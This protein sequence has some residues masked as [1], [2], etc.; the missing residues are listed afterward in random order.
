[1]KIFSEGNTSTPILQKVK[2][3]ENNSEWLWKGNLNNTIYN[4]FEN[5]VAFG[6]LKYLALSDYP[7]LKDVWYG[8]LH[9]NVFCSLKHLVVERHWKN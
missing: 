6:K 3:A 7:E 2:I 1:M 4:M 5:K 8:Q 9:C